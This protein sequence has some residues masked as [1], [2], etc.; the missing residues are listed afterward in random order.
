MLL[1]CVL[2]DDNKEFLV[3]AAR[4]LESQGVEVVGVASTSAEALRLAEACRPDIALVDIELD[5]EDGIELAA[6]IASKA[7]STQVVLISSYERDDLSDLV[8][9]STALGFVPK[10]MLSASAIE[11]L[12][13]R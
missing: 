2:V 6:E 11:S 9:D 12:L 10:P 7:P 3:S 1:R 8:A 13:R 5:L 4:L